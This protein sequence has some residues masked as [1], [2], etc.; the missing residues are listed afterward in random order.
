[1]TKTKDDTLNVTLSTSFTILS[2]LISITTLIVAIILFDRFGINAKFKERQV[3]TVLE[4]V[5]ELKG[6]SLTV[7]TRRFTYLN[8]IRKCINLERL[9]K[10]TYNTDKTKTLLFPDNYKD[11]LN[12]FSKARQDPWLPD[13]IKKKL[14]FIDINGTSQVEQFNDDE[15]VRLNI[16]R[17][18]AE[19]W[20]VTHPKFTFEMFSINLADLL[21]TVVKWIRDHSNIKVDFDII[22]KH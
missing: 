17:D 8:Y 3:D 7:S 6:I 20:R 18:G 15:C 12:I 5:K 11:L 19:P 10:D 4:F 13:E 21:T 1:M 2:T 14:E 22:E 9:P 16:N